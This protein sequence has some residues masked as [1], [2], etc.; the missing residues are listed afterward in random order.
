VAQQQ[1][2]AALKAA[3]ANKDPRAVLALAGLTH[4]DYVRSFAG[5]EL[6]EETPSKTPAPAEPPE[7]L[8][9]LQTRLDELE[10][11]LKQERLEK[12]RRDVLSAFVPEL[13]KLKG[14][15]PFSAKFGEASVRRRFGGVR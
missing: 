12:A 4:E 10:G 15:F 8:K 2:L 3:M 11:M 6:P 13:E 9:A 1:E 7:E 14:E 5:K